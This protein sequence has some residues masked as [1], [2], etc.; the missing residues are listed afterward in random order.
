MVMVKNNKSKTTADK[1]RNWQVV[2]VISRKAAGPMGGG[3]KRHNRKGRKKNK[4][5]LR[6]KY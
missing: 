2:D 3:K 6:K 4:Q 1:P 5:N